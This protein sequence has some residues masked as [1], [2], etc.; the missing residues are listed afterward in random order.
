[1][2]KAVEGFTTTT[3]EMVFEELDG[4]KIIGRNLFY[5]SKRNF[6]KIYPRKELQNIEFFF[7]GHPT[8]F[9]LNSKMI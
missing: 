3:S 1:M 2:P 4:R 9:L 5:M 7:E 6:A 8:S